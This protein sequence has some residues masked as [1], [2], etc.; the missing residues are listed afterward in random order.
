MDILNRL[1]TSIERIPNQEQKNQAIL[2]IFETNAFKNMID[3]DNKVIP[4][5]KN[6][7]IAEKQ[8]IVL[9]MIDSQELI[10]E[11]L[12]RYNKDFRPD[13]FEEYFKQI[14][15]N[16]KKLKILRKA[17]EEKSVDE[18]IELIR[19]T[20]LSKRYCN[21]EIFNNA[22]REKSRYEYLQNPQKYL[23]QFRESIFDRNRDELKF[24]LCALTI[25]NNTEDEKVKEEMNSIL[26]TYIKSLTQASGEKINIFNQKIFDN[27]INICRCYD[28]ESE[29][30]LEFACI[31]GEIFGEKQLRN[32]NIMSLDEE[33]LK[34]CVEKVNSAN[35]G[36]DVESKAKLEVIMKLYN[37]E[38]LE[39]TSEDDK[40]IIG[41]NSNIQFGIE[42]EFKGLDF[43]QFQ[44]YVN[45]IIE[46]EE[47]QDEIGLKESEKQA[48]QRL[49]DWKICIDAGVFG[50]SEFKS[51]ILKDT[52][53]T[54]EEIS[55]ASKIIKAMGGYIDEDCFFHVH[56]DAGALGID[57]EAWQMYYDIQQ[58]DEEIIKKISCPAGEINRSDND[59]YAKDIK[60]DDIISE[61]GVRIESEED[62]VEFAKRASTRSVGKNVLDREK[63]INILGIVRGDKYTIEDRGANGLIEYDDIR[64][65][66][67]K[68]IRI[69]ELAK[70]ISV[71][72]EFAATSK[73]QIEEMLYAKSEQRRKDALI[74]LAFKEN[75]KKEFLVR[76]EKYPENRA[77]PTMGEL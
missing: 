43:E 5:L 1:L 15:D 23:Q 19:N 32:I 49:K 48:I 10:E 20:G 41:T 56:I 46:D 33:R 57:S 17:I 55:A 21:E 58:K 39:Q 8:R 53:E 60:N 13:V 51:D 18:I 64:Y 2:N 31:T 12:Y 16:S 63:R 68:P 54:W 50:G 44:I 62:L 66:I 69:I 52:Q 37:M 77:N 22:L 38:R 35:K 26:A 14:D 71:D 47:V 67:I 72:K 73:T 76:Y 34:R 30:Q 42:L 59:I 9:K 25:Y 36:R 3:K 74:N 6:R 28:L 70:R 7:M 11:I 61:Y 24:I 45:T 40:S 27:E 4:A 29:K 65:G 75:E